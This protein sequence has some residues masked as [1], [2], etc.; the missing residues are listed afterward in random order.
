MTRSNDRRFCLLSTKVSV[1]TAKFAALKR[2]KG[3]LFAKNSAKEPNK[4]SLKRQEEEPDKK[5]SRRDKHT[6]R[7]IVHEHPVGALFARK[8]VAL[9]DYGRAANGRCVWQVSGKIVCQSRVVGSMVGA[10]P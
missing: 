7:A 1:Y 3:S 10:L 6:S 4:K 8:F 5:Q 9:V 2:S